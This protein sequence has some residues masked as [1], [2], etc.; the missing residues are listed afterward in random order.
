M[1]ART[2]PDLSGV[3]AKLGRPEFHMQALGADIDAFLTGDPAAWSYRVGTE[4]APGEGTRYIV[5]AVV[6]EPPPPRWALVIGDALQNLN[7]ALDHLAWELTDPSARRSQRTSRCSRSRASSARARRRRRR[8]TASIQGTERSSSAH[9]G[10]SGHTTSLAAPLALLRRL[11]NIDMHRVLVT[12]TTAVGHPWVGTNRARPRIERVETGP[13][14]HESEI[15]RFIVPAGD[16]G[17]PADVETGLTFQV[18]LED[19]VL[20]RPA[21]EVLKVIRGHMQMTIEDYLTI[22]LLPDGTW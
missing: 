3:F 10:I 18:G 6:R 9:S 17:E 13:L 14:I 21:V 15:M 16:P 22:G 20:H 8:W 4:E 7:S 5:T 2:A 1:N 12:P 19:D 11:A